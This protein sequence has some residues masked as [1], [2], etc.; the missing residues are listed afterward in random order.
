VLVGEHDGARPVGGVDLGEHVGDVVADSL[1]ADHQ[2]T[3]DRRIV[4][5]LGDEVPFTENHWE[6]FFVAPQVP[7][8]RGWERQVDLVRNPELYERSLTLDGYHRWLLD[9]AVRWIAVPSVDLD[10]GGIIEAGLVARERIAALDIPWLRPVWGDDEWRLYEVV[11]YRPIVDPPAVLVEQGPDT[12]VV[13][14]PRPATVTVRYRFTDHLTIGGSACV[15]EG[16]DGWIIA[17]LPAAGVFEIGVDPV[18]SWRRPPGGTCSR[19]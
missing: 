3:G 11:D 14:T 7:Y 2:P 6:S 12:V 16:D 9:N 18:A 15:E 13:E 19:R 1:R 8:A 17:H 5:A 10:E 4:E